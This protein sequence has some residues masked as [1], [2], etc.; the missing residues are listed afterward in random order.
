[1]RKTICLLVIFSLVAGL[2][3]LFLQAGSFLVKADPIHNSDAIVVLMGSV[4]D[5]ALY[6]SD[7]VNKGISSNLIL[8]EEATSGWEDLKARGIHPV[9]GSDLF[10]EVAV[11]LG[12]PSQDI[13]ILHGNAK[14]TLEEARIISSYLKSHP[15]KDTILLISSASHTRRAALI[16][17]ETLKKA[18][19][20]VHLMVS[21]SPY[22]GF[23]G[24]RWWTDKEKT[25]TVFYEWT[26]I[27]S[28]ILF[29]QWSKK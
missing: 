29:E 15:G 22:S 18:G 8:A 28:F 6:A 12:I 13:Q 11:Q 17:H 3:F 7:L 20:P 16:F 24:A 27:I 4:P 9:V 19:L 25:A 5:R 2:I 21:P 23:D 10:K 26:K 14:S 1:M